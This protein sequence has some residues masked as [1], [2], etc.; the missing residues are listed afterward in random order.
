MKLCLQ[1]SYFSIWYYARTELKLII[2]SGNYPKDTI[3]PLIIKSKCEYRELLNGFEEYH[4]KGFLG[5]PVV[6]SSPS[7]LSYKNLF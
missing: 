7:L 1:I 2:W 5:T 6:D 3:A 4:I